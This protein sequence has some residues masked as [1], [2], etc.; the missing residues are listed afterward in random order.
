MKNILYAAICGDVIGSVYEGRSRCAENKSFKLFDEKCR[1][2]DDTVC[3]IAIAE[4]LLKGGDVRDYLEKWAKKYPHAGYGK[5]FKAWFM[6][7]DKTQKICFTPYG[8]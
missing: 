1:F 2:T 6:S 3:T 7:E 8:T 5:G 4:W